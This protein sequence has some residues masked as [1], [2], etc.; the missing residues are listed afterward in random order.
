M[1]RAAAVRNDDY[2]EHMEQVNGGHI[3]ILT[4]DCQMYTDLQAETR[5]PIGEI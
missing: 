5:I 3:T 4:K 1:K 2:L